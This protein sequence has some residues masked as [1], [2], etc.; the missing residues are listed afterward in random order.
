MRSRILTIFSMVTVIFSQGDLNV[1]GFSLLNTIEN[2]KVKRFDIVGDRLYAVHPGTND[3]AD[4]AA[5]LSIINLTTG[6]VIAEGGD[7]SAS[8]IAGQP[9]H[10]VVFGNVAVVDGNGPDRKLRF[11]DVSSDN[12][13]YLGDNLI[14]TTFITYSTHLYKWG[15]YLYVIEGSTGFGVYDM[16]DPL[17]PVVLHEKDYDSA[18]DNPYSIYANED[19][20]F[21]CEVNSKEIYIHNNGGSYNKIGTISS[22]AWGNAPHRV[23]SYGN[24]LYT[25]QRTVHNISDP[26]NPVNLSD[27]NYAG[28]GSNGHMVIYGDDLFF[29]G[30]DKNSNPRAWIYNIND[31]TDV[32]TLFSYEDDNLNSHDVGVANNKVYFAYS[33]KVTSVATVSQGFIRVYGDDTAPTIS[34]V[35]LANDNSTIAVTMSEAVFNTNSGSGALEASDFSFSLSGG[36][37]TLSSAT[38]TSISK[39]GNVYTLGIS[40]SGTPDGNETL[41]V[42]PVDD[43]IYDG[44]GKEASTDQ[45]NNT[46]KLNVIAAISS[47]TI[48]DDNSIITV[49]ISA[50]VYN[51]NDASGNLEVSDFVLSIN[52]GVATLGSS[53]PTSIE[54]IGYGDVKSLVDHSSG[55]TSRTGWTNAW[56]TF[57][58]GDE[59][60]L[61]T[62]KL[63]LK[64][65]HTASYKL[66]LDVYSSDGN[67]GSANPWNKF[68][69]TPVV[70]SDRTTVSAS[71][72]QSEVTFNFS[73][74]V[75]LSANTKYYFWL[76]EDS[77]N[78]AGTG[79]QSIYKKSSNAST[80]DGG[81]GN[82]WGRIYHKISVRETSREVYKLGLNISG[83]PNGSELLTVNPQSLSI[84]SV[85]GADMN[86]SQSNNTVYLNDKLAPTISSVSLASDNSTIAVTM[87][88]SVFNT[89]GGSGELE[90]NDF[91]FSINGGT[92]TLGSAV[93]TSLTKSSNIYTLGINLSGLVDGTEVLTVNPVDNGIYDAAG[94]EATTSQSNNTATLND[95][96]PPT[97]LSISSSATDGLYNIADTISIQVTF[98]EKVNVTGTPQLNLETGSKDGV[99]NYSSGTGSAILSFNYIV[100]TEHVSS[101]LDYQDT[102][103]LSLNG[104]TINDLGSNAGVLTLPE[105]GEANSLG[106]NK[107]LV[108]DGIIPTITNI[109]ISADNSIL[110]L[111]YS[112]A[113]FNTASGS[114]ALDSADFE[115]SV[116]SG[117]AALVSKTPSSISSDGNVYTLGVNFSNLAD[118]TDT[119]WVNAVDNSIYDQAGNEASTGKS[120]IK[121]ND[122]LPPS[123]SATV[124]S[125]QNNILLVTVSEPIYNSSSGS[126]AVEASDFSLSL[127]EGNAKLASN[128][129]ISATK[130][131]NIIDNEVYSLI[132]SYSINSNG[133]DTLTVNPVDDGIYD[134]AGNEASTIQSNNSVVLSDVF[135]PIIIASSISKDNSLITVEMNENVYNTSSGSGAL[136]STDFEF[137]MTGGTAVLL[138]STPTS[139]VADGK[140]YTLGLSTAGYAYGTEKVTVS[141][142]TGSIF[143][144]IGNIAKTTQDSNVVTLNETTPPVINGLSISSNN[145]SLFVSMS[146]PVFSTIG[147]SGDLETGDFIMSITGG[148]AT[149]INTTPVSITGDQNTYTLGLNLSGVADGN[150]KLTINP[151]DN[152]I[153]DALGN[154]AD[155]IQSI[156]TVNL[157]DLTPPVIN[158]VSEPIAN[159]LPI[160]EK[161][162]LELYIS[163][164]ISSLKVSAVTQFGDT[165]SP[166]YSIMNKDTVLVT[167]NPPFISGDS[168]V[169]KISDLTDL[170]NNVGAQ[171]E[172]K[173]QISLLADFNLDGAVDIY[174]LNSFVTGWK[175]KDLKYELGPV[176]RDEP[177]FKPDLDGV[178]NARDGMVFYRMWHWNYN[179]TGKLRAQI[180]PRMG[181]SLKSEVNRDQIVI[182][183][184]NGTYSSEIIINYLPN[185]IHI[186][187]AYNQNQNDMPL[188]LT[189][190]D[191]LSGY[192][193]THQ[194]NTSNG[195]IPFTIN[196][197]NTDKTSIEIAYR[198]FN[199][200]NELISA[201]YEEVLLSPVPEDFAL[202]Q[203]Y[204]NPFNPITT[205]QYDIPMEGHVKLVIYDILGREVVK[206]LDQAIP[207][208]YHT[209]VWNAKDNSGI[210]MPGGVYFYQ[211]QTR[212]YVKTFKM[213]LLK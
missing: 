92:A 10:V 33:G 38:P 130:V 112:E 140:K 16:T 37:A 42:N 143:D 22:N 73:T 161:S 60:A 153:Y 77:S 36:V 91:A 48:V 2:V 170:S 13:S 111:T 61:A 146:E 79:G 121:L 135:D 88:E 127:S 35:S 208:G 182:I 177:N 28:S 132:V 87:S 47:T 148:T 159:V 81:S 114:G 75:T 213:I 24:L 108:I 168:V 201:G 136:D 19:Y 147:G 80:N 169:I 25:D 4:G 40:L 95:I 195:I 113:I 78:P 192:L 3:P 106:A 151:L 198:Y 197:S 158:A 90:A 176:T 204:P 139:I 45:S 49:T 163:E 117:N 43:S 101:D 141:P 128:S 30:G 134:K 150:E 203:N 74:N 12:I 152:S 155:T 59:G 116:S 69:G 211:L 82:N 123:I 71:M 144:S 70:S 15:N 124:V 83:T 173:Y 63:Q 145:N 184:P 131:D 160:L 84:Y 142:V 200:D 44:T 193:L 105:P 56:Q 207:S 58:M 50:P 138:S 149:L 100:Y 122:R 157:Y 165:L 86:T 109:E 205:I 167:L 126:G 180:Y 93:P 5:K 171:S 54:R 104:G 11:F 6:A 76:K 8:G 65:S 189:K 32:K 206:L 67:S 52:G 17:N 187:A 21:V 179:R 175:G 119:L 9:D 18:T 209:A 64:N 55:M 156:N 188:A 120:S 85:S 164:P 34:S 29:A 27:E 174:D 194:I 62:V 107:A 199:K 196:N 23:A 68:S 172:Y 202:H 41:T 26:T 212:D 72:G 183:P 99:A 185:D 162:T 7:G 166:D 46:V 181:E 154:E 14:N 53:T 20:I 97:V 191:T 51:T 66:Y 125:G 190:I 89:S 102:T 1:E 98:S 57:T 118:G 39:N 96:S 94:N 115:M 133:G 137:S 129:P 186:E 178:F 103:S 210:T 31:Y 110:S